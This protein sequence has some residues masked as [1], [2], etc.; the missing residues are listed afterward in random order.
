VK[1]VSEKKDQVSEVVI[2]SEQ[3]FVNE[4]ASW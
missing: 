3:V 2:D 4:K 1:G